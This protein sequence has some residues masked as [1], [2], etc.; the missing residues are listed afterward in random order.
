MKQTKKLVE[1]QKT[2]E[3]GEEKEVLTTAANL[4]LRMNILA[5]EIL[6]DQQYRVYDLVLKSNKTFNQ[7]SKILTISIPRVSELWHTSVSKVES[8]WAKRTSR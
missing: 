1:W 7:V 8:E 4:V 2:R 5:R 3:I 6:T